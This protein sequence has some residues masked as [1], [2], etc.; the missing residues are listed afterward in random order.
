MLDNKNSTRM[1]SLWRVP[2]W[3]V[4]RSVTILL[5]FVFT[6]SMI[7]LLYWA[8]LDA[9]NRNEALELFRIS[10][11]S[12][13]TCDDNAKNIIQAENPPLQ[14]RKYVDLQDE[15]K[16]ASEALMPN[17]QPQQ[18]SYSNY[19][20]ATVVERAPWFTPRKLCKQTCC[21]ETVAIS[22]EQ[23][24]YQ[25]INIRDGMDLA[26]VIIPRGKKKAEDM[27][28]PRLRYFARTL[29]KAMLPCLVP[30]TI[31]G[32]LNHRDIVVGHFFRNLRPHIKVPYILSTSDSDAYSPEQRPQY[33]SDPLLIKWYGTNPR[34]HANEAFQKNLRKFEPMKVGL[35]YIYPQEKNLLP[36]LKLNKFANP[37]LDK[38]RW[39]FEENDFDFDKDV[40]VHFGL[41]HAEHR[42]PLWDMLCPTP[43]ENIT[44]CNRD[45]ARLP[46][47]QV[48]S[49]MS[50]YRFGVS[51]P[52][53]GYDCFRTYEMLLLGIIPIIEDMHPDMRLKSND[54]FRGLPIIVMPNM[55]KATSKQQFMDVIQS[56]IASEKFQNASFEE[57]WE[58][59]FFQ[60]NRQEML[61]DAKRVQDIV[62]D[63]TGKQFYQ[64]YRY[65]E[66]G[67]QDAINGEEDS[68]LMDGTWY[69][70]PL[71]KFEAG[72]LEWL[73]QWAGRGR[74]EQHVRQ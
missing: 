52:G 38:S 14:L 18:K 61:K 7:K 70:D 12:P 40:F 31:I 56:Y 6:L 3:L 69:N 54:L 17:G 32:L 48:Y 66:V 9:T 22:L 5:F 71:P 73:E 11:L 68:K 28:P 8:D 41:K 60:H 21:V 67:S 29:T 62:A 20:R 58:H 2:V 19:Q 10:S 64:A 57:G 59:L 37:F 53:I 16:N 55:R 25:L 65:S 24:K 42:R 27:H 13:P 46:T 44:S 47:H 35:S 51:P 36:Y 1:A 23:D 4:M 26:D 45:T 50:Q 39:D 15:I 34:N 33:L 72:E 43:N 74:T 49:D 30:G 63:D